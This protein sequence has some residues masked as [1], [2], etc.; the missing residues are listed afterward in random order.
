MHHAIHGSLLAGCS[1]GLE[2]PCRVVHPDIHALDEPLGDRDVIARDEDNLSEETLILGN[3]DDP[4][5]EILTG[6]V[7]R[8]SLAGEEELYR[9]LRI[10]H[11]LVEPVKVG[12]QQGSTLVGCETAG[13]SDCQD[14][15]TQSLV[16]GHDLSRRVVVAERRIGDD[17]LDPLDEFGFES[18][19][20]L[21][22]LGIRNIVDTLETF[23]VIV[24]G[25]EL[26]SEDF[27]M[28]LLPLLGSPSRIMH[29]IGHIADVKLFREITR[30]HVTE[31]LLADLTVEP[32][33]ANDVLRTVGGKGAH[34]ETLVRIGSIDLSE[35]H[36]SLPINLQ[37]LRIVADVLAEHALV[38]SIVSRR[39]R[40]VGGEE[41]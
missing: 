3:L 25:G 32:G 21:P 38:E 17:R 7:G 29:T 37:K 18:L 11:D 31:D 4:L 1:G 40:G 27:G 22:D 8:V 6:L 12:E 41:G 20:G 15:I 14:I 2:R 23:P 35:G 34:R 33:D 28:D 9:T 13:E 26:R 39:H 36:H 5:D 10:V 24:M 19:P 16:D 30:I